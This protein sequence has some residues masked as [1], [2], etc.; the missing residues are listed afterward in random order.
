MTN[1]SQSAQDSQI[2]LVTSD[3]PPVRYPLSRSVLCTLSK[4]F[5]DMLTLPVNG[6]EVEGISEVQVSETDK[7][8]EGFIAFL[9]LHG[10]CGTA[11]V[12]GETAPLPGVDET[13][14]SRRAW[15]RFAQAAVKYQAPFAICL[16]REQF[17]KICSVAPRSHSPFILAIALNDAELVR[18][19]CAIALKNDWHLLP[20]VPPEWFRRI[21]SFKT[22]SF[23]ARKVQIFEK[24]DAIPDSDLTVQCSLSSTRKC[25]AKAIVAT[26]KSAVFPTLSNYALAQSLESQILKA[27]TAIWP[28]SLCSEHAA[29]LAK[30]HGGKIDTEIPELIELVDSYVN[31][32][33]GIYTSSSCSL[34]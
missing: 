1:T 19:S 25:P 23:R 4:M 22:Y 30:T 2:I 8:L 16:V 14:A 20:Y 27:L 12:G 21:N 34:D 18:H 28:L 6:L 7:K 10:A 24:L 32:F 11:P 33:L 29:Q 31:S 15:A 3:D 5:E 13:G 17:W 9:R 26:W